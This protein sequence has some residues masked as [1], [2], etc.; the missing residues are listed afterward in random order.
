MMEAA[1]TS[2]MLVK[3][4]QTA[5]CNIPEDRRLWTSNLRD[6][7][8]VVSCALC[9][10]SNCEHSNFFWKALFM[11]ICSLTCLLLGVCYG[12]CSRNS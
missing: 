9:V 6:I 10:Q 12:R 3:F 11:T 5:H 7:I 2:E 1:R 4:Y 8:L